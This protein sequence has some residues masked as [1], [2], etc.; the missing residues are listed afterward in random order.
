VSIK[1]AKEPKHIVPPPRRRGH[2][3][4]WAIPRPKRLRGELENDN[5]GGI[6]T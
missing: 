6:A 5:L 3:Q 1:A 2:R 4:E